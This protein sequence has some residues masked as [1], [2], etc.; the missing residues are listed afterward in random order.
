[1]P[2][3]PS[4]TP[5]R[6]SR[7]SID[8]RVGAGLQPRASHGNPP[9]ERVD[10]RP[11]SQPFTYLAQSQRALTT[12]FR[13]ALHR[14]VTN[15]IRHS[16]VFQSPLDLPHPCPPIPHQRQ[17]LQSR[18]RRVS[19]VLAEVAAMVGRGPT[20]VSRSP[21]ACIVHGRPHKRGHIV[22]PVRREEYT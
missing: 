10:C 9:R 19:R 12:G 15:R 18:Q 14:L 6:R 8:N 11:N 21:L 13:F 4:R 20:Q 22:V 16:C 17:P 7:R 1:M 5:C 2:P 3:S